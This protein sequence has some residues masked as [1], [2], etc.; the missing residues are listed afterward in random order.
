MQVTI[1]TDHGSAENEL[2]VYGFMNMN[3]QWGYLWQPEDSKIFGCGR[4]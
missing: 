3:L 1:P 2:Q 4:A